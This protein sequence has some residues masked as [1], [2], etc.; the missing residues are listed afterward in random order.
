MTERRIVR[1]FA[2]KGQADDGDEG[3][4]DSVQPEAPTH[5]SF[6]KKAAGVFGGRRTRKPTPMHL[7]DP[8]AARSDEDSG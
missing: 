5:V 4:A 7:V 6:I 2:P 8:P 3:A 1:P